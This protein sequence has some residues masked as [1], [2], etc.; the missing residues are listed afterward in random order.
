MLGSRHNREEPVRQPRRGAAP[1]RLGRLGAVAR[2]APRRLFVRLVA[3]S[4]LITMA[5]MSAV[6][7]LLTGSSSSA[8]AAATTQH[9]EDVARATGARLDG[10]VQLAR[11]ELSEWAEGFATALSAEGEVQIGDVLRQYFTQTESV[12]SELDVVSTSGELLASTQPGLAASLPPL[13]AL[14]S[15]GLGVTILPVERQ[16]GALAWF[17][18]AP[19]T[20]GAGRS[21]GY[22]VGDIDFAQQLSQVFDSVI[23]GTSSPIVVEAV[24]AQHLLVFST[25]MTVTTAAAALEEGALTQVVDNP[26]TR[27]AL[28]AGATSGAT[29]YGSGQS[30]TLAGYA[31]DQSLGWAIVAAEPAGV[32]LAPVSSQQDLA[33]LMLL[34]GLAL[35]GVAM[36]V[37]SLRITRPVERLAAAARTIARGDLATRVRPSGALEVRE[38]GESFNLM[39]ESLSSLIGRVR[40]ASTELGESATRLFAASSQMATT[41]TQQSSAA[42]ETSAS[43]EELARTSARIAE[44][45]ERV[46]A[47]A[48]ITR[49]NL[50]QAQDAIRTSSDR[51]LALSQ[52][53]EEIGGILAMIDDIADETNLLAFN[54]A[55]EAA[56]AG[57]SGR[58][59]AV[60]ADEVRRLA[61][62]T[63]AL[64]AEIADITRGA[65]SETQATV[66]AMQKGVQQLDSG[67]RLM[68]EVAEASSQVRLATT[69]QRS[70]SDHVMEAMEQVSAASRQLSATSQEIAQAAGSHASMAGDLQE[71][72]GARA[73]GGGGA[74]RPGRGLS[75][76]V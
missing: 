36:V 31:Y 57:D 74:A 35:L 15:G 19:V 14:A 73:G 61:D 49:E 27:A 2:S 16:L 13:A 9:L 62:R 75:Q 52:R 34:G 3:A 42:E 8:L 10:W 22:L 58:G 63:K 41:T 67:L 43:M 5:V 56:R 40:Q 37:V 25:A 28:Q 32:A 69:E 50:A 26:A 46:A 39:V 30:S 65:E 70:A 17:A 64:A 72:A 11:S 4:L 6:V 18:V 7:L 29:Q 53:V 38:L 20:F 33:W 45:I 44:S 1:L 55:I 51:T 59:F 60:V 24:N 12:F 68:E 54:A 66:Q 23:A 47:R 76:R 48:T 21:A 71:A